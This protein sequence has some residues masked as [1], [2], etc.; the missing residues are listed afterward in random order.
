MKR[1]KSILCMS[2]LTISLSTTALAGDI[3]GR[4]AKSLG[5]ITGR[6]AKSL[7]DI[8]GRSAKSLGDITGRSGDIT[9]LLTWG[10]ITGVI[11]NILGM[12]Q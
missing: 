6:S 4:S 8:T 12:T 9:G 2:L 1:Y 10:D 5:D 3:T 11:V 7:G